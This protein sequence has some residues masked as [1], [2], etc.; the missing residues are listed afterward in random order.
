MSLLVRNSLISVFP[1]SV[2]FACGVRKTK[3]NL[4]EIYEQG[5]VQLFML[6]SEMSF[7]SKDGAL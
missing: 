7:S 2:F 6:H 1:S 3:K 5:A 4:I